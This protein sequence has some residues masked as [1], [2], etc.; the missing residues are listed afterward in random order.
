MA[1][2]WQQARDKVRQD[3]WRPG[4]SGIPDDVVDRALHAALRELEAERRWL[5][6]ENISS[7]LSATVAGSILDVPAHFGAVSS[8]AYLSGTTG[9]DILLPYALAFVRESARGTTT[10]YPSGYALHNDKLYLDTNVKVGDDFEIVFTSQTS[11]DIAATI[12]DPPATLNLEQDAIIA[13]AA[14]SVALSYL[15]NEADASRQDTKYQRR[16]SM[17]ID[18]EDRARGDEHGGCVVPDSAY[19]DSAFGYGGR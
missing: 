9:Y 10:S 19:R 7:T 5:W 12:A 14:A 1:I 13:A 18:I 3:L 8:L 17:L 6:L 11:P 16:L 4:T 15:K 2:T